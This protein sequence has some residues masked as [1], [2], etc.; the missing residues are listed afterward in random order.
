MRTMVVRLSAILL[1]LSL[2][3]GGATPA[4]AGAAG[5]ILVNG[6]GTDIVGMSIRRFGTQQWQ[7]L[8]GSPSVGTRQAINF[9]DPDCAFDIRATLAGGVS[10]TWT[11]VN[12]CEVKTVY[13][14]RDSAS[15]ATWVDYD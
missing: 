7:P 1:A 14:N 11:G 15:A 10:V 4:L 13:L 8:A 6:T 5:F 3:L 12:L 9:S 2:L